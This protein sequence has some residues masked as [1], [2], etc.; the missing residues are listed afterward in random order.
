MSQAKTKC[1]NQLMHYRRRM[2]FSQLY[3][4]RLMNQRSTSTIS[5]LEHGV[6]I[7][8][9]RNALKLAAIYRAPVE[10]LFREVFLALREEIRKREARTPKGRQG[11]LP[12]VFS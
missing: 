11:V 6:N 1:D 5:E 8:T 2:R 12:I 10:F 9:L 4:A 7:P 3:V